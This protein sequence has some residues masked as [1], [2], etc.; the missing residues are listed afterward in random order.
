[1]YLLR[2]VMYK[3]NQALCAIRNIAVTHLFFPGEIVALKS[4]NMEREKEGFPITTTTTTTISLHRV[5]STPS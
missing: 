2:C 3:I 5:K 1:M 4:L